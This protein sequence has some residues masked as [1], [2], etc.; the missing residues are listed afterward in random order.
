MINISL[1]NKLEQAKENYLYRKRFTVYHKKGAHISLN[2]CPNTFLGKDS[3]ISF[4][5]NDYL[6]LSQNPEV[7]SAFQQAASCY[8]VGSAGSPLLGGYSFYHNKLESAI[9][10]FTKC[11]RAL[12]FS[13]G[14]SANLCVLTALC[15]KK[16]TLYTDRLNHASLIDG[17][18][19]SKATVNRYAHRDCFFLQTLLKKEPSQQPWVVTEGVFS[20]E[21]TRAPLAHLMSLVKNYKGTLVLDDSHG[22][23]VLGTQGGGVMEQGRL[24]PSSSTILTGSFGKAFGTGGGF[25]A[26]SEE[27]IETLIQKGRSYGYSCSL[28]PALAAATL[29]S[30]FL[31]QKAEDS[32]EHL[33]DLIDYFQRRCAEL[34]LPAFPSQTPIQLVKI[35]DNK[36]TLEFCLALQQK[37]I[38]VG[39]IRPPTV[40]PLTSRLR[41]SLTTHHTKN[42]IEILLQHL[43][44]LFLRKNKEK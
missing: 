32:R 38:L 5:S 44:G 39:A 40:P 3:I 20:M 22:W 9:A 4:I 33:Q 16:T 29:K 35:G 27:V 8:G 10:D 6:G 1:G 15:S 7:I 31:L 41:I 23:G 18:L 36:K 42:H 26:G 24:Y 17:A 19:F 21:G 11:P 14:F 37:G 13:S 34:D 43:S 28:P 12:L 25:V 30:L 2:A